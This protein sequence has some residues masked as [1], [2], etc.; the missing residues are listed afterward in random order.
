MKFN[1]NSFKSSGDM[2]R[3]IKSRQESVTDG[4]TD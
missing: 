3:T 1:E 4:L 2:E